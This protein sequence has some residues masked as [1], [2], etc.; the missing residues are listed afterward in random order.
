[1]ESNYTITVTCLFC[2][3]ALKREKEKEFKSGDL[4]KC[5]E[6]GEMNDYDAVLD[7]AKEKGIKVVKDEFEKEI[8]AKFKWL[9]K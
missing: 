9:F 5:S 6:C 8:K 4:I 3:A 2:E 7:I 1:M